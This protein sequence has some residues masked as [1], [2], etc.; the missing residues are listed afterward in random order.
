MERSRN[1]AF[2]AFYFSLGLIC[3]H[4]LV[5]V[6]PLPGFSVTLTVRHKNKKWSHGAIG[7]QGHVLLLDGLEIHEPQNVTP[8]LSI[9]LPGCTGTTCS[10]G[11]IDVK[12]LYKSGFLWH[13]LSDS[14]FSLNCFCGT[15]L[16]WSLIIAKPRLVIYLL[17]AWLSVPFS[18]FSPL[19]IRF[20]FQNC[21]ADLLILFFAQKEKRIYE[22]ALF[23][24]FCIFT[25]PNRW[26]AQSL[27]NDAECWKVRLGSMVTPGMDCRNKWKK[28]C[29][30]KP[31]KTERGFIS[32][33]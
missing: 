24:F 4:Y 2:T 32:V 17:P 30:A 3:R 6:N 19:H 33:F 29:V 25:S 8:C 15:S 20:Q 23:F 7:G 31:P 14:S 12:F 22:A 18:V 11:F 21:G 1:V 26:G 9:I 27:V 10:W 16:T 28:Y 5:L 13:F